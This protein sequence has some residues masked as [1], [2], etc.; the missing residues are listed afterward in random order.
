MRQQKTRFDILS[1]IEN[2]LIKRNWTEY[3][4]AEKSGVPQ[5]TISSWLR[6]NTQPSVA[7]LEQICEAF[8]IS[9]SSFFEEDTHMDRLTDEQRQ[10]LEL[11][12]SLDPAQQDV[13]VSLLRVFSPKYVLSSR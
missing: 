9:L 2:E 13:I 7:S 11:W 4:L 5:S 10:L 8:G 1:R 6:K 3:R 12:G